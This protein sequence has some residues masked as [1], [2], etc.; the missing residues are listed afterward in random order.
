MPRTT[1][2]WTATI[3]SFHQRGDLL[4]G[5]GTLYG[6]GY[7]PRSGWLQ[8][9]D[10]RKIPAILGT[11]NRHR[12][13]DKVSIDFV[14]YGTLAADPDR[15]TLYLVLEWPERQPLKLALP[16]PRKAPGGR[17]IARLLAMPWKHYFQRGWRLIR[18]RQTGLL[19]RKLVGMTAATLASGWHPERLLK[20][21]AVEGKPLALVIDHDLGGGAN[22]YRRSLVE[23]LASEGFVP[24]LL[25]THHGILSYQLTAQRGARN[26]TANVDDLDTLFDYLAGAN[27]PR[28]V[29]NNIL[30]FPA[31][32]ALVAR[33][34][35]W[36]R[37]QQPEQFLFL[38]HDYYSIC[39]VW[40]LLDHTG[41][42][43]GIPDKA[44]CADC[45]H[46]NTAL[47][48]EFS[49]GSDIANWRT[50][51]GL[52]LEYASE[53]RCFSESSRTLILRAHPHLNPDR[54]SI[55]PHQIEHVRLRQVD[56]NDPGWPVI[57]I[58]GQIAY[59]KGS[60]LVRTLAEHIQHSGSSARIVIVGTIDTLLPPDVATVT[61]PYRPDQLPDILEKHGVNI[62]FFPSIC[63]ET[64]SYVAEEMM[65]MGLPVVTLDI[66]APGERVARYARGCV[67]H[68]E[69]PDA[70]L[71]QIVAHYLRV[72]RP[73]SK[74]RPSHG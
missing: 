49:A 27:I 40:L 26:R 57:G 23:R 9:K 35:R 28:I 72:V 71:H 65:E 1:D 32:L 54:L 45:L 50:S 19:F 67:I 37:Q 8:A 41:K 74:E 63:P 13:N 17:G 12:E 14:L 59:H 60:E 68:S 6:S 30:S 62:G 58:I 2:T 7:P 38:I 64:F 73:L 42:Y 16:F 18:Q 39:P 11:L 15:N 36:L 43:C 56:V 29:F 55:V 34:T 61:G 51:W 52:L 20:W 44:V 69:T 10:G 66:G 21:A 24:L 31:P 70:V 48:L 47:F 22:L 25:S 53:I 3:E 5:W 33:L 46:A 4:H